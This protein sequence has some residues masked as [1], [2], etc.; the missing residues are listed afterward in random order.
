VFTPADADLLM[1]TA[2][3][4]TV[5]TPVIPCTP[6]AGLIMLT[7]ILDAGNQWVS[8]FCIMRVADEAGVY[9]NRIG[10]ASLR[11]RIVAIT[12]RK[13]VTADADHLVDIAFTGQVTVHSPPPSDLMFKV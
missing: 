11:F 5:R 1:G 13:A 12:D 8:F 3:M 2:A 10:A 9:G 6:L 7:G 4:H